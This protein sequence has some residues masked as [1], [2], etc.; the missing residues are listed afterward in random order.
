MGKYY[1][2]HEDE[3][4]ELLIGYHT[5]AA[6]EIG[7]VDNWEWAGESISDYC[8]SADVEDI[9]ELAEKELKIVLTDNAKDLVV[10]QA[11]DPVYGARPLKRYLQKN[12]ETLVA[13]LILS[14]KVSMGDTITLINKD[15]K[16]DVE[17]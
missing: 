12:V 5:N 8:V 10:E 7:G 9:E 16:L 2:V 17:Q 11:Y 13:R 15:G 1:K 6:L 3:L 14:E 4:R